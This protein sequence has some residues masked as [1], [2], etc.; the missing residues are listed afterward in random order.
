MM[1][2]KGE[3][4]YNKKCQKI[5]LKFN[6]IADAKAYITKTKSCQGLNPKALQAVGIYLFRR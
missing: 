6:S 5:D 3:M 1:A 2:K 4:I